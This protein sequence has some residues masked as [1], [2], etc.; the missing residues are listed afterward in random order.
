MWASPRY[1]WYIMILLDDL[2]AKEREEM[3]K[4]IETKDEE[5]KERIPRSV[6]IHKERNYKYM[7]YTEDVDDSELIKFSKKE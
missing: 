4:V 3:Q 5:I 6:P 1:A 2:F 7:I